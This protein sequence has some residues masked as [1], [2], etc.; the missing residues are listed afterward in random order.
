MLTFYTNLSLIVHF[1]YPLDDSN[2][3]QI[4]QK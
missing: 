3:L 1:E 4:L 2:A